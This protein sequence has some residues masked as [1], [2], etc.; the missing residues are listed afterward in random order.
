MTILKSKY[1]MAIYCSV[2]D[3]IIAPYDNTHEMTVIIRK[4]TLTKQRSCTERKQGCCIS[5]TLLRSVSPCVVGCST[6]RKP[7]YSYSTPI[8]IISVV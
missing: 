1:G 3:K 2:E 4:D 5:Q 8:E 6:E 7:K